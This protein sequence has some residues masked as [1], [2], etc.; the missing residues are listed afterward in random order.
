MWD[1]EDEMDSGAKMSYDGHTM[2]NGRIRVDCW[3]NDNYDKGYPSGDAGWTVTVPN[4]ES[5]NRH[6]G[7][8]RTGIS[9]IKVTV[10]LD[11]EEVR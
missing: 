7:K 3:T 11:G 5:F 9:G 10:T 8:S 2:S 6:C 4:R 1:E